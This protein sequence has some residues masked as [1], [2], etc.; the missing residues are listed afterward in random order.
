MDRLDG[1]VYWGADQPSLAT[2]YAT[3]EALLP[4]WRKRA[5][6]A[7]RLGKLPRESVD[8]L[9]DAGLLQLAMPKRFGGLELDWPVLAEVARLAARACPST[10]WIVGLVGGHIQI[11]SRFP[12]EAVN[13]VFRSGARQL[14]ATGSATA[15][16]GISLDGGAYRVDGR[17]RLGS[18]VDYAT[19]VVVSGPCLH[20]SR[21]DA[22]TVMALLPAIDIEIGD[23]WQAIGMAGTGS[24]DIIIRDR[25]ISESWAQPLDNVLG[26]SAERGG[27]YLQSVSL[28]PYLTSVIVGPLLGCAEGAVAAGL[29]IMRERHGRQPNGNQW[30]FAMRA[31]E[32]IADI[33][34]ARLLYRSILSRLHE[35]GCYSR[36]L[37]DRDYAAIKRDR[38]RLTR[39]CVNAVQQLVSQLGTSVIAQTHPV[40]RHWCDLQVMAAH[41]D[42]NWDRAMADYG[43]AL[44][45]QP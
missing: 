43:T 6:E 26:R 37:S 8:E 32:I 30:A 22:R 41:M 31:G 5:E 18:G 3:V 17:W 44:L 33:E 29:A 34:C 38:A 40:Q 2:L 11:V 14:V 13:A 23:D 12:A 19:W 24:R 28:I 10:A 15:A 42:V 4:R 27:H 16:G 36:D 45:A 39:L 1:T 9:F 21:R 7:R 25:S 20:P 35:A